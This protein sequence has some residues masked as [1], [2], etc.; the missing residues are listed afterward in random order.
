[1]GAPRLAEAP[2]ERALANSRLAGDEHQP[3]FPGGDAREALAEQLGVTGSSPVSP[4]RETH[5]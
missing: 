5:A 2:N 3:P 4:S 1:M